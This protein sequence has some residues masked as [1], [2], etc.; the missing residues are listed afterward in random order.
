MLPEHTSWHLPAL[1]AGVN[2]HLAGQL[3][4]RAA[5]VNAG[6]YIERQDERGTVLNTHDRVGH[7]QLS[8]SDGQ[9]AVS[10]YVYPGKLAGDPP[11]AWK[12]LAQLS[13][14][15]P[16]WA[17]RLGFPTQL[18]PDLRPLTPQRLEVRDLD[19]LAEQA[20]QLTRTWQR[21][22]RWSG[23]R[24]LRILRGGAVPDRVD[25]TAT[26]DHWGHGGFPDHVARDLPAPLLPAGLG[27]LRALWTDLRERAL[28]TAGGTPL[29]GRIGAIL[30]EL[31]AA[32]SQ[33]GV[34]NSVTREAQALRD[35]LTGQ[36]RQVTGLPAGAVSMPDLYELWV[37]LSFLRALNATDGVFR[38][39]AQGRFTGE[40]RGPGVQ[41]T[42]NPRLGFRGVGAASQQLMPDLLAV[43]GTGEA[44]VCDVMT[45]RLQAGACVWTPPQLG[46]PRKAS[47]F[48]FSVRHISPSRP[49]L[50][51]CV[52]GAIRGA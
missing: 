38:Q 17:D 7:L 5:N 44:V 18:V 20:W 22:P 43:F 4:P 51:V 36:T 8:S 21:L 29:A 19:R 11:L 12:S 14:D 15:L 23:G 46:V 48:G 37:Q 9:L 32:P 42:L 45:P 30:G 24:A 50:R 31:P 49:S 41:I 26:L 28:D 1:A 47:R 2:L 13:E 10:A 25:W 35:R 34:P 6:P 40:F 16:A 27:E 39:D 3:V 52:P 33:E